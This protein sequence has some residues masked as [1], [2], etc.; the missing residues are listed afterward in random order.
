MCLALRD[1]EMLPGEERQARRVGR[2]GA[3]G[4]AAVGVGVAVH[5]VG[6]IGIAGYTA[7]LTS[8]LAALGGI[9]G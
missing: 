6:A 3:I 8:G 7:G 9:V 2:C 1:K 5:T 4:G